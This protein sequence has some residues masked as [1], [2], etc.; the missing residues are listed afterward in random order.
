MN[1][2]QVREWMAFSLVTFPKSTV[3]STTEK[4]LEEISE[5]LSAKTR[6]E[7]LEEIVDCLM[8]LLHI[9]SLSQFSAEEIQSAFKAKLE[10]NKKRDWN[11]NSNNTYSHSNTP[12]VSKEELDN[13]YKDDGDATDRYHR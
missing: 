6:P 8:C 7:I 11:L 5:L 12:S 9:G 13:L 4:M 3:S 2:E 1:I 10:I